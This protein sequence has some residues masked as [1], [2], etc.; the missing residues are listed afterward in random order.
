MQGRH[1]VDTRAPAGVRLERPKRWAGARPS[2]APVPE[3]VDGP[4][5]QGGRDLDDSLP[6]STVGC[7]LDDG[8][9]CGARKRLESR[10]V[11]GQGISA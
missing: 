10:S 8:I 1:L 6:H 4:Q 9:S 2:H 11:T 3:H 7:I 5:A